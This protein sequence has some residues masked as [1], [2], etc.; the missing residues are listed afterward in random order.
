MAVAKD[1]LTLSLDVG[2]DTVKAEVW[3]DGHP[4][5]DLV[6]VQ[7]GK[8]QL[9]LGRI[10]PGDHTIRV[11]AYDRFLNASTATGNLPW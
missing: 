11:C 8:A 10:P 1:I 4:L 3:M 9:P 7:F 5:D 2:E 6:V